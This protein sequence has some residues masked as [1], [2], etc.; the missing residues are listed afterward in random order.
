MATHVGLIVATHVGL[1]VV[2]HVALIVRL[3]L[4]LIECLK[5]G[6]SSGLIECVF[7]VVKMEKT[8]RFFASSSKRLLNG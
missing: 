4:Y 2:T 3:E 5:G 7:D 6:L 1:I 8:F